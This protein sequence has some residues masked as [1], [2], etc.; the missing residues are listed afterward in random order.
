MNVWRISVT[1]SHTNGRFEDVHGIDLIIFFPTDDLGKS[2]VGGVEGLQ[3]A[4]LRLSGVECPTLAAITFVAP[5]QRFAS[6]I[7]VSHGLLTATWIG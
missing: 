4:V 7:N 2:K 1:I 6:F 5:S 3:Q